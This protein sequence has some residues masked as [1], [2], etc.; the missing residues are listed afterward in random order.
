M[1]LNLRERSTAFAVHLFGSVVVGVAVLALIWM[2]WYPPPLLQAQGILDIF[3]ILLMVDVVAGPTLTFLVYNREKKS[4]KFDLLVVVLLQLTALLYGLGTVY[5]GRPVYLVFNVDRFSV[6][7]AADLVYVEGEKAPESAYLDFPVWGPE[8]VGAKQPED[9]QE[10]T[11]L[12]LSSLSGGRDLDR[13]VDYYVPI[14]F[15]ADEIQSRLRSLDELPE[16][17]NDDSS[18]IQAALKRLD[19]RS[20]EVGYLPVVGRSRNCI[21]LIERST[22][23]VLELLLL[24]PSWK[25]LSARKD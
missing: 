5:Q 14:E 20:D 19:A 25:P 9:S 4:L 21:A 24:N 12:L 13:R 8:I 10:R 23:E 22:T 15:L 16:E 7:S 18:L 3:A 2:V 17:N 11:Q 1:K 6:I